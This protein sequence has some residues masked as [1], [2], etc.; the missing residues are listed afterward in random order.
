MNK[1][2]LILMSFFIP[3]EI[4]SIEDLVGS[5]LICKGKYQIIGYEFHTQNKV[6][7]HAFSVSENDYYKNSGLYALTSEFV[8]LD[9]DGDIFIKKIL[10]KSL[11]LYIGVHFENS[12]VG[13]CNFYVG[14]LSEHFDTLHAK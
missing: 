8:S 2:L 4:K 13:E 12:Q 10:R 9:I 7:R 11:E 5:N 14:N 6:I 3:F 1:V